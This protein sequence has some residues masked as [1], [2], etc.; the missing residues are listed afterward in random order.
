MIRT[1]GS[2]RSLT[3]SHS[4]LSSRVRCCD[5]TEWEEEAN[6]WMANHPRQLEAFI[7]A[8]EVTYRALGNQAYLKNPICFTCPFEG[9]KCKGEGAHF[10]KLNRLCGLSNFWQHLQKIHSSNPAAQIAAAR[11]KLADH[12]HR[13]T[14]AELD[15]QASELELTSEWMDAQGT[16]SDGYE[17]VRKPRSDPDDFEEGSF[18]LGSEE[19]ETFLRQHK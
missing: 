16:S 17:P 8:R 15:Q 4:L 9:D 2:P 11:L 10:C 6:E 13:L 14:A 1:D 12:A 3:A 19:H 18:E 5:A 7:V